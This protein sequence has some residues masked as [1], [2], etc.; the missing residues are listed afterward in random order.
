M[1]VLVVQDETGQELYRVPG[2][3]S[4]REAKRAF[5][6][7]TRVPELRDEIAKLEARLGAKRA[8]LAKFEASVTA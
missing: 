5:N 2:G 7:A 8:E 3:T 1:Q 4:K 6:A